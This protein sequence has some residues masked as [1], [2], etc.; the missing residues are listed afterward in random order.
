M[1]VPQKGKPLVLDLSLDNE[2][3]LELSNKKD[4]FT[5]V[6]STAQLVERLPDG[7]VDLYGNFD[8]NRELIEFSDYD[9]SYPKFEKQVCKLSLKSLKEVVL[10]SAIEQ[11]FCEHRYRYDWI[12]YNLPKGAVT[13]GTGFGESAYDVENFLRSLVSADGTEVTDQS[14][15]PHR[16]AEK[17]P[18]VDWNAFM[19]ERMTQEEYFLSEYG[20]AFDRSPVITFAGQ[21]FVFSGTDAL[22]D[23]HGID[24]EEEVLAR[25][26]IIRASV[27][28]KT[29]YLVV[30]PRWSGESKIKIAIAQQEK[31]KPV[32]VI[33]GTDL[34]AALH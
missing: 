12:K 25:G 1:V 7:Y 5:G 14:T 30:D 4:L 11:E 13:G 9:D 8:D 2:E 26:G 31:G 32:K 19:Q 28:G 21:T 6:T 29:N 34:I 18:L 3:C 17:M 33:L 20:S 23:E 16:T 10:M 24:L 15:A 27:S 22:G